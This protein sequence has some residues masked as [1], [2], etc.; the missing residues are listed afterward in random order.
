MEMTRQEALALVKEKVHTPELVNHMLATAAIMEGLARRLGEDEEK[1]YL[2]GLLHDIDYEET[3][4]DPDRHSLVAG[5]MLEEL[6]FDG[7]IVH[8][9]KA[10]NDHEGISRDT[11]LAKALYA[12]DPL[13]GLIT[14][15]AYVMPSRTLGEVKV[16]SIK[17]KFK[18][19]AFARGAN[20][21]QIRTCEEFGV[22]LEEFFE[23]ALKGMQG[24]ASSLGLA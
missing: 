22:P 11:L 20:R 3:K 21:D 24:I 12:T 13:S 19:K 8:A 14:A 1:W 23:I 6:G 17:K 10:H 15:T 16:K 2:A 7:E 9:V 4:D 5:E 18:D